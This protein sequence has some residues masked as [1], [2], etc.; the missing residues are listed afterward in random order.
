M[1]TGIEMTWLHP[2]KYIDIGAVFTGNLAEKFGNSKL[3]YKHA[4][5]WLIVLN[6]IALAILYGRNKLRHI[7]KADTS[8][9][10]GS[11]K[12]EESDA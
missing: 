8:M 5:I 11:R 6:L 1:T 2:I 7:R 10:I 4:F 12:V 3:D 9:Q